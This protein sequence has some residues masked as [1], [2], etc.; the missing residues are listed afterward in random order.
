MIDVVVCHIRGLGFDVVLYDPALP[1]SKDVAVF[2]RTDYEARR[3]S[4][5]CFCAG[6]A[7]MTLLHEAGHVLHFLD[8][9]MGGVDDCSKDERERKAEELGIALSA[10]LGF[11]L[12]DEWKEWRA[13]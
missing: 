1:R 10:S 2:G 6:C 7:L 9:G 11:S 3:V 5:Y 13:R 12:H 8:V 4:L